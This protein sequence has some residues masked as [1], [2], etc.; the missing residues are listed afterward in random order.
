MIDFTPR[1]SLGRHSEEGLYARRG[2]FSLR[3]LCDDE[4]YLFTGHSHCHTDTHTLITPPVD[5]LQEA[6]V[7]TTGIP[8]E[9]EHSAAGGYSLTTK[10][11]GK[12]PATTGY[13]FSHWHGTNGT[14]QGVLRIA[15]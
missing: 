14:L 4:S 12:F 7:L 9:M 15:S 3:R 2:R 6:Q 1:R 13:S 10:S 8:A 5:T 11:G